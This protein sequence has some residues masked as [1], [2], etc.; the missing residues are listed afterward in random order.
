MR[1]QNDRSPEKQDTGLKDKDRFA[2]Q[3][4]A[5]IRTQLIPRGISD[6]GVLRAMFSVP[7]EAFVP[8][9]RR[10]LAYDDQPISVGSGQTISQPYIV[11]LMTEALGVEPGHTVLE[12]GTGTGY[13]TAILL[14]L[15]PDVYSVERISELAQRAEATLNALGYDIAGRIH[16]G[17]GSR[18][19]PG[20]APYDAIIV[21]SAT[22]S[23][24]DPLAGQ[25]AE[26]GRLVVPVGSRFS[27]TLYRS[28]LTGGSLRHEALTGCRFV[29]LIGDYGWPGEEPAL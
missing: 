8:A 6:K 2:A 28:V 26:G 1:P 20:H 29:P 16:T 25:L 4:E 21:T 5:M 18:G 12:I 23:V 3:R 10:V 13:Q 19:L 27:Q 11:A 17:D 9:D 15:T 24:P 22:P 14:E 7:R